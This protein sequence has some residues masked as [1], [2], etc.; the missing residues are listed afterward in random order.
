[1][2]FQDTVASDRKTHRN[3]MWIV[4]LAQE[5]GEEVVDVIIPGW[6]PNKAVRLSV[7]IIR[8]KWIP[9][10][11]PTLGTYLIANVN[12]GA[13]NSDDLYFTHFE[14]APEPEDF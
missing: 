2:K 13:V 12:N 6:N 5:S 3:I 9:D 11:Q 8:D 1:M 7:S 4:D 14:I 10:F